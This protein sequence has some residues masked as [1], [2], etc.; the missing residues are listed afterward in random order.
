M[1]QQN[2]TIAIVLVV[3]FAGLGG[4]IA[5]LTAPESQP[6]IAPST[7]VADRQDPGDDEIVAPSEQEIPEDEMGVL[8][9]A[10]NRFG[11]MGDE[12][13]NIKSATPEGRPLY[14]SKVVFA[15]MDQDGN[16]RY[17]RPSWSPLDPST[18]RMADKAIDRAEHGQHQGPSIKA[19]SPQVKKLQKQAEQRA[20]KAKALQKWANQQVEAGNVDE[21]GMPKMPK[22]VDKFLQK[23]KLE[24]R[25]QAE[26]KSKKKK[27]GGGQGQKNKQ[28]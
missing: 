7:D 14:H 12:L 10:Q 1:K 20:E 24:E 6:I 2:T 19:D 22:N 13:L 17:T 8:R 11:E 5:W 4:L 16:P 26:M 21:Q 9:Y 27:N 3:V 18:L 23:L 28:E 25:K 15:G